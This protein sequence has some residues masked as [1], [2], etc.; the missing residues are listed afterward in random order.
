HYSHRPANGFSVGGGPQDR[1]YL[2]RCSHYVPILPAWV[3]ALPLDNAARSIVMRLAYYLNRYDRA[4][5]YYRN[6]PEATPITDGMSTAVRGLG[7][8]LVLQGHEVTILAQGRESVTFDEDGVR[9]L[10]F[11]R[12]GGHAPVRMPHELLA[13]IRA[14]TGRW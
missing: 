11:Q 5:L 3:H 7:R 14:N 8:A 12:P 4:P 1:Q 13:A 9:S 2:R 10:I 6:A